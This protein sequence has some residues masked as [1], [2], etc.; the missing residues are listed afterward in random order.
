[1]AVEVI[2]K[3]T[4]RKKSI[5]S[6]IS[7]VQEAARAGKLPSRVAD[8]YLYDLE[9]DQIP[10]MQMGENFKLEDHIKQVDGSGPYLGEMLGT[11]NFAAEWKSRTYYEFNAGRDEEPLIY[12]EIYDV[13]RDSTL[14]KIIDINRIG[15]AGVVFE[16]VKEGGEV[17]FAT[18]GEDSVNVAI[19]NYAVGLK[20]SEDL[21]LYNEMWRLSDLERQFGMAHN[22]LLNHIHMSLI[23]SAS[24][25]GSNVVDGTALT[26]FKASV[27]IGEKYLR[28]LEAAIVAGTDDT[29]NPRRGPYTLLCNT[30]GAMIFAR[31]LNRVA[32]QGLD[33]QGQVLDFVRN[34]VVY[35]GW[36][37]NRGQKAVSYSG[38][39]SGYAY[40]IDTSYRMQDFR[41]FEKHGLRM[42]EGAG[43]ASRFIL[44]ESIWN[45]RFGAYAAPTRAVT[46]I[47]LP[48]GTS[49]AS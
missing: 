35:N 13:K 17:K 34:I 31:A 26:T 29:T 2:D 4:L 14:P 28:A 6:R 42:T 47:T 10:N 48:T 24:Y 7:R 21:V 46:K 12:D 33:V 45:S 23:L 1:M 20:Y 49:G 38:V 30:G 37:G 25:S 44:K 16:E 32:Q 41:S 22:A 18:V 27:D 9:R 5:T 19:K 8:Q 39:A 15:P 3:A 11:G 40:L 36:T 43:D